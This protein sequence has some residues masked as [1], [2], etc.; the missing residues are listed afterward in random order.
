[1]YSKF[2]YGDRVYVKKRPELQGRVTK[3]NLDIKA[4]VYIITVKFFDENLIPQEME[5]DQSELENGSDL[6][7]KICKNS[8]KITVSPV[9]NE[10]WLDCITCG[11]T[12]EEI[13]NV[14]K[15]TNKDRLF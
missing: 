9:L 6:V 7:C 2:S 5:F 12:K 11:K 3:V 8:Y 14:T 4:D 15:D 13:E 10:T 1:M